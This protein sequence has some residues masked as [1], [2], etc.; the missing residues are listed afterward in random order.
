V[1]T[2]GRL[3]M[4]WRARR[5]TARRGIEPELGRGRRVEGGEAGGGTAA[6][7]ERRPGAKHCRRQGEA[8]QSRGARA[9]GRRREG[10]GPGDWFGIL[11]NFRD[12]S[13]N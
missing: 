11:K 4:P 1:A 6:A 7:A 10:R 8:E 2:G 3:G 9:R 5:R 13:V 12:L